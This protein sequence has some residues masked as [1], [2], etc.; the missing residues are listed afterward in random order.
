MGMGLDQGGGDLAPQGEPLD[1]VHGAVAQDLGEGPALDQLHDDAVPLLGLDHVVDPDDGGMV[2]AR[3]R[4]RLPAQPLAA[5]FVFMLA[6]LDELH[7]HPAVQ[8][9]V[10]GAV[11]DPHATRADLLFEAVGSYPF[12]LHSGR[13]RSGRRIS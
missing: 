6:R 10:V 11:D 3:A 8:A 5:H 7:R 13:F 9:L 12:G 4:P 1:Q 2:Q